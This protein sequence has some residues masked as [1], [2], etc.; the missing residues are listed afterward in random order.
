MIRFV[1]IWLGA[2]GLLSFLL[3]GVDKARAKHGAWR[4]PERVLLLSAFAGGAPGALLGML[5]F[6]HK[7]RKPLFRILVPLA[8]LLWIGI[9]GLAIWRFH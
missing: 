4:I 8:T 5:L 2:A 7:T 3:F 9:L 6:R 1:C